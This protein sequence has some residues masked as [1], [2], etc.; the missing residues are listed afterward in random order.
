MLSSTDKKTVLDLLKPLL[1]KL[2]E[3]ILEGYT[4]SSTLDASDQ[5]KIVDAVVKRLKK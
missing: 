1:R 4:V 5:E 2:I 3:N